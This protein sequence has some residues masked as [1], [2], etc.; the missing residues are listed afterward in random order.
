MK[1]NNSDGIYGLVILLKGKYSSH[2]VHSIT[3]FRVV[4]LDT[5]FNWILFHSFIFKSH[6][7][8]FHLRKYMIRRNSPANKKLAALSPVRLFV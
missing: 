6:S 8:F 1:G 7:I 2:F 4:L 3:G 5:P